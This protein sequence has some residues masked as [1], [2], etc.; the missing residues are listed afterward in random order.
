MHIV[1]AALYFSLTAL[2]RTPLLYLNTRSLTPCYAVYTFSCYQ[3]FCKFN[4]L[5]MY[6]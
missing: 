6:L 3:L 2:K 5:H 4:R 1:H